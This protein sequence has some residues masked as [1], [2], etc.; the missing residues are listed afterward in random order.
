M[1]EKSTGARIDRVAQVAG[2][3]IKSC[4]I[5]EANILGMSKTH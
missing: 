2:N 3:T 1:Q 5:Y 4:H